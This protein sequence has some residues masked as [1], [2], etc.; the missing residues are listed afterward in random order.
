MFQ[1]LTN[2][3][4]ISTVHGA[5]IMVVVLCELG[6]SPKVVCFQVCMHRIT[7]QATLFNKAVWQ[8]LSS[9][10]QKWEINVKLV[11]KKKA[12][13]PVVCFCMLCL[14]YMAMYTTIVSH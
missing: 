1:L 14:K 6:V 7:L 2:Q 13:I 11:S 5:H 3:E 12:N 10:Y 9:N 8:L 4:P